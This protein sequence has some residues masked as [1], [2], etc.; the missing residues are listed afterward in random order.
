VA[1]PLVELRGI[2]KAFPG[3]V[4][5]AGID[6]AI[7]PGEVLALLG[8]NGAGKSTIMQVLAG[9]YRPDEGAIVFD[10]APVELRS[11]RDAIARGVGMVH[12]HFRLVEA[13]TV[14]ENV[15][16]GW[17]EP[18]VVLHARR[19]AARVAQIAVEHGLAVDPDARIAALSVGER[20][21]VEILKTLYRDARVLILD[22][23]TAVLT[24]QEVLPLFRAMRRIARQGRAVVFISHKLG[25]VME[26]ADRIVVLRAGHVV[27]DVRPT[28]TNPRALARM[29]VG[30]EVERESRPAGV[31]GPVALDL[32]GLRVAGERG[33]EALHDV[34]LEVRRGEIVGVAGVAGN[35]QRELAEAV[36]GVRPLAGGTISLEGRN[37]A[38]LGPRERWL[39][40][41]AYVPEDRIGE[42]LIGAFDLGDNAALRDY[43]APPLSRGIVFDR[44]EAWRRAESIIDRFQVRAPGPQIAVRHLS[45][46]N[47]QRLLIG[48]ETWS[49]RRVLVA[50]HPSRGLDVDAAAAVHRLLLDLR[51]SGTAILLISESLDELLAVA[52]RIVV[53]HRGLLVG[54]RPAA[55]ATREEIGLLMAGGAAA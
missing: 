16:L 31:P 28:E 6:L 1:G 39:L 46:G 52:D 2:V 8:E 15:L 4:A 36:A 19:D 18:R 38:A 5:N 21:R 54:E 51:A 43:A 11:P 22:E 34:T 20:Q 13:F 41:I 44:G 35:G 40:G 26:I 25:E 47:Q 30:H 55:T 49:H 27:G 29:M 3:V 9:V 50:M 24:P 53:L 17:H 45:G 12:Q 10:G 14:A 33:Y 37:I 42:G 23:P 7:A 32:R 48:R